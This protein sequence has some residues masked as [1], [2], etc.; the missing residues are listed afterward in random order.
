VA[1]LLDK[2]GVIVSEG[3]GRGHRELHRILDPE[4]QEAAL[5]AWHKFVATGYEGE[6]TRR[7]RGAPEL[8][9][10]IQP[11]AVLQGDIVIFGNDRHSG[12]TFNL[13][14]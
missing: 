9:P 10:G 3:L 6:H 11:Q 8:F 14:I 5:Q 12:F 13:M 7:L 2:V 1:P 4:T